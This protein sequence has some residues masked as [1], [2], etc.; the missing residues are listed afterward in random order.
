MTTFL[1]AS[2]L[3]LSGSLLSLALAACSQPNQVSTDT[4]ASR[5]LD[6]N[7]IAA[8]STRTTGDKAEDL[9]LGAE[10]LIMG[11]APQ[12]ADEVL[13]SA[14]ALDPTNLR[15]KF[16]KAVV[17]PTME[18]RGVLRRIEPFVQQR[19]RKYAKYLE[20][21]EDVKASPEQSFVRFALQGPKD[22]TNEHDMQELIS[23]FTLRLDELR[24]A[25]K[26][27][28]HES[29]R[30]HVQSPELRQRGMQNAVTKC[31]AR[32]TANGSYEI[33][34]CDLS[35]AYEVELNDADF[36]ALAQSVAGAQVYLTTLNAYN[37]T[38]VYAKADEISGL[39]LDKAMDIL[40][41]EKSF[42]TLREN[43]GF[44]IIPGLVKDYVLA[45]REASKM[46][47]K[48]CQEPAYP[49]AARRPGMLFREGFCFEITNVVDAQLRAVEFMM[50]GYESIIDFDL[51]THRVPVV[52]NAS[53]AFTSP[54]QDLRT[55]TPIKKDSCGNTVG[56]G[57]G[58][59]GGVFPNGDLNLLLEQKPCEK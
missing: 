49:G 48:L 6:S 9:A 14:L 57:D 17:A 21:I 47:D 56:V 36:E 51:G 15:A 25:M 28:K 31:M 39:S 2:T 54:I 46:Q 41:A 12:Y 7:A 40:F 13:S 11:N 10:Q 32:K 22:I 20:F 44:G 34:N 37:L 3:A 4:L 53:K 5:T 23:R 30:I 16:W 26:E 35:H 50:N 52:M 27:M 45:L 58:R 55:L 42:G 33:K 59:L 19:P 43:H 1:K 8:D 18:L 38:G 29:L 24:L